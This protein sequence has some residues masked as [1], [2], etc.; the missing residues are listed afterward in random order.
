MIN[1][2]NPIV[3]RRDPDVTDP[4]VALIQNMADRIFDLVAA[5]N[6]MDDGDLAAWHP[7]PPMP[8][9]QAVLSATLLPEAHG[10]AYLFQF[11]GAPCGHREQ[12]MP[13]RLVWISRANLHP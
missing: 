9:L 12:S 5:V 10:Q 8:H 13:V 2:R 7:S 3:L 4:A 6:V 11:S 1:E